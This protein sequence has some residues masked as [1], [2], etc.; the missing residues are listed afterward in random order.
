M[1]PAD[2]GAV[3]DQIDISNPSSAKTEAP[4]MNKTAKMEICGHM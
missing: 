3:P 2:P 1:L 4:T